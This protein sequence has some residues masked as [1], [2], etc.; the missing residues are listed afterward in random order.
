MKRKIPRGKGYD[1]A[2]VLGHLRKMA[3]D[4]ISVTDYVKQA[5]LKLDTFM[6]AVTTYDCIRPLNRDLIIGDPKLIVEEC[7]Q[8]Q[9]PYW[10]TKQGTKFCSSYCGGLYR[11]D[12]E[13]FGGRRNE[14]IGL[15]EAVCQL[16]GRLVERGLS[17]HHIYGKQNDVANEFLLALCKGC[18]QIVSDLALK[19]WCGDDVKLAKLIW[20]AY[21]QRNGS[22][23]LHL[24]KDEFRG[25]VVEVSFQ[26]ALYETS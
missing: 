21:T 5:G 19:T 23:M 22:E 3:K 9:D 2:A 13:Y 16:C 10:P 14:T 12:Q 20:L 18:H 25:W 24:R 6:L 11:K 4:G 15:K 26:A 17:S 7:V 1:K 8:C